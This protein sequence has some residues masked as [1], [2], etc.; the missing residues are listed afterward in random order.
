MKKGEIRQP[1]TLII[2][3]VL[4][5]GIYGLFWLYTVGK[6]VNEALG[7][8]AVQPI[9]IILSILCFPLIYYY[10]YQLDLALVELA[11][12]E[13]EN[14]SSNFILWLITTIFGVG[15]FIIEIQT[16]EFLNKIWE[17]N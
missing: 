1:V 11:N 9:I 14:Y 12:A 2:L 17:K 16:Q 8:E 3:T 4:T 15:I 7:R 10:C 6:E 5:C 13:G